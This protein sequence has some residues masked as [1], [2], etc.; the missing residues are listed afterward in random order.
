MSNKKNP[1]DNKIS[2]TEWLKGNL[3]MSHIGNFQFRKEKINPMNKKFVQSVAK[4]WYM[5]A[6]CPA[7][8]DWCSTAHNNKNF[9]LAHC[10]NCIK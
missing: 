2:I 8:M 1:V 9:S 10:S 4:S 7:Q 6:E 5:L 3:D